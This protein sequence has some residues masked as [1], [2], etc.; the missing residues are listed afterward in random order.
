MNLVVKLI[1]LHSL[2][3][4]SIFCHAQDSLLINLL[5]QRKYT[6]NPTG[7]S[8]VGK[9]WEKIDSAVKVSNNILIGE[10]HFFNEIPF[11][12]SAI[13]NQNSFQNFVVEI[14]P[15][16]AEL[17][18][19][20]IKT[21]S[22]LEFDK[23]MTELG[24]TFSFYALASEMNLLKLM[25]E[26]N[27]T[28]MGTDQVMLLADRL[29]C[30]NLKKT[31]KSIEA[32]KLYEYI[33]KESAMHLKEFLLDQGKPFFMFTPAFDSALNKLLELPLSKVER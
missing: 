7:N 4:L 30:N 14:D 12:V 8:F 20:K 26:K 13:A 28:V 25:V 11:F 21:L 29:L 9:G 1:C 31:S 18:S 22:A 23:F 27:A 6:F 10:D 17:I 32:K 15:Y 33:E 5:N 24:S 3:V 16:S 2:L 19:S